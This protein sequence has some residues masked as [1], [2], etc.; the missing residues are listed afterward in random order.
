LTLPR[1]SA[2][3]LRHKIKAMPLQTAACC[4]GQSMDEA[5]ASLGALP[6]A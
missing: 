3:C 2:H 1:L 4:K 6:K 5:N